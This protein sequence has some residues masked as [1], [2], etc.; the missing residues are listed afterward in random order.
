MDL[1]EIVTVMQ[2]SAGA[3]LYGVRFLP[4][5]GGNSKIYT[6]KETTGMAIGFNDLVVV[7]V[8]D[9]YSLARVVEVGR[10]VIDSD[11]NLGQLR[12]IVS[13]VPLQDHE[14]L[15]RRERE[16]KSKLALSEVN[17]KLESYRKLCGDSFLEQAQQVL[18][19]GL[20]ETET[21]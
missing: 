17:A 8:R 11:I 21:K 6:Y 1:N 7:E 19:G 9:T 13:V 5:S 12:H 20:P 16:A 14:Q 10:S 15:L 2:I 3:K 18:I 4:D